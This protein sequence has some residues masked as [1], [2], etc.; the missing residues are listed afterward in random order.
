M[1]K[2]LKFFNRSR[3]MTVIGVS[4]LTHFMIGFIWGGYTL[5]EVLTPPE[6]ILKAEPIP[7]GIDPLKKEY[8]INLQKSQKKSS[9][10]L[11][12]PIAAAVPSELSLDNIDISVSSPRS[13]VR[14]RGRNDSDGFGNGFGD[15]FGNGSGFDLDI[16]VD[17]N[18][19][20]AVGGG[21][22]VAFVVDYSLSM[23]GEKDQIL[24]RELRRVMEDLP[25]GVEFAVICFAGVAWGVDG[26]IEDGIE[27]WAVEKDT[28]NFFVLRPEKVDIPSYNRHA[29]RRSV[30]RKLM[31]MPLSIGTIFDSPLWMAMNLEPR[32]DTIF[33]MT[34]GGCMNNRG[35]DNLRDMVQ[36]LQS[37]G[38]KVPVINTVGFGQTTNA[39]LNAIAELTGGKAT[40]LTVEQYLRDYGPGGVDTPAQGVGQRAL[41]RMGLAEVPS[42]EV[43]LRFPLKGIDWK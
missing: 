40:F 23:R 20:G 6:P 25:E 35:I 36:R 29:S 42:S 24:R 5:F 2:F 19:F 10:P 22:H 31:D 3:L 7:E 37:A 32:P 4:I 12:A 43:K 9:A 15:G 26:E 27:D 16:G 28:L 14:V 8:K 30:A 11:P 39:Q 41:V 38:E 13:E 1:R 21:K 34:D 18:F 33:F 17:I